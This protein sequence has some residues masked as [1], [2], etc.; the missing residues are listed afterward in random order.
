MNQT[1]ELNKQKKEKNLWWNVLV[2]VDEIIGCCVCLNVD[3]CCVVVFSEIK[4]VSSTGLLRVHFDCVPFLHFQRC[5]CIILIYGLS[6]ETESY[7][8]HW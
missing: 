6:I 5:R 7:H 2:V 1:K 4:L 8:L 3:F